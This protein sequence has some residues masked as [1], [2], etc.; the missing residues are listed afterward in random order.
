M[1][2]EKI[3]PGIEGFPFFHEQRLRGN[4][5]NG[6]FVV[7]CGSS[8]EIQKVMVT[9]HNASHGDEMGVM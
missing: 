3:A 1:W 5:E 9:L 7:D 8:E 6:L 2:Y 4:R